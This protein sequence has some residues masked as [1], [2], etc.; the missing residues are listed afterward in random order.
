MNGIK[1]D[2]NILFTIYSTMQYGTV[3]FIQFSKVLYFK[4]MVQQDLARLSVSK[5]YLYNCRKN[6]VFYDVG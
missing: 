5:L 1:I 3:T 2:I 6:C 4:K